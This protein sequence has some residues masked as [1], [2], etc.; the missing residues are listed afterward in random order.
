MPESPQARSFQQTQ[1][2]FAAYIRDPAHN[3][4][5]GG[6]EDRRM[7][8]YREL[9]YNNVESFVE[10]NFPVLRTLLDDKA[11]HALVQDFFSRHHSKTPL[12]PEFSQEFID[13]LQNERT[14]T[15]D[16][17]PFMLELAH[18]EWME[19][20][21]VMSDI[22]ID[23][24]G[25]DPHGDLLTG[26]PAISPLAWRFD[27]QWPVH[28]ISADNQPIEPPEHSTHIVVYRDRND[29]VGFLHLNPVTARL[30]DLLADEERCLTGRGALEIITTEL[31]HS[32]PEVLISGGH[33]TLRQLRKRDIVLGVHKR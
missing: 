22:E 21:L 28:E 14:A 15:P 4:G 32:Q 24:T 7:K 6:I 3:P 10:S 12:F 29:V 11:W 17:P 25:V 8:L 26:A 33:D 19:A 13:Y 16:D 5:P 27:Y 30:I 9:F 31:D 2:A 20:A 1:R 18:Y 23:L